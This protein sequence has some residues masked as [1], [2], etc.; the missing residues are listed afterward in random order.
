VDGRD[1]QIPP[2][3]CDPCAARP[4][5][6]GFPLRCAGFADKSA[7]KARRLS[8]NPDNLLTKPV[9]IAY[10]RERTMLE[11]SISVLSLR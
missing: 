8:G 4:R 5:A 10:L 9:G 7:R 11:Y 2:S 1:R 6:T 3:Y